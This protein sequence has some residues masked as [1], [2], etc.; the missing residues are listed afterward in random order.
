MAGQE[1]EHPVTA[2]GLLPESPNALAEQCKSFHSA[3]T[4]S[5]ELRDSLEAEH[6]AVGEFIAA[7]YAPDV[8]GPPTC[9]ACLRRA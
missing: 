4:A 5:D 3:L 1:P 7:I 2:Q 8:R 6:H 9:R